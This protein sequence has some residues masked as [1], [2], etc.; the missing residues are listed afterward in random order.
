MLPVHRR[1]TVADKKQIC[2]SPQ[3]EAPL[4][5]L[6]EGDAVIVRLRRNA[7]KREAVRSS[8]RARKL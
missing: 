5:L 7:G 1:I 4:T 8:G 6:F 3:Y 2:A